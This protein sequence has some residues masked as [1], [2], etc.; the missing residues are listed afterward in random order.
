MISP[1]HAISVSGPLGPVQAAPSTMRS[2]DDRFH[3]Q[4]M[5][6]EGQGTIH[7]IK[8]LCGCTTFVRG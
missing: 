5:L 4:V 1:Q 7:R 8:S 2:Y 3:E 6:C